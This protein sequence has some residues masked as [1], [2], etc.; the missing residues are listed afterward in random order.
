MDFFT[1][2]DLDFFSLVV[3][4]KYS[5]SSGEFKTI[6]KK[7]TNNGV[8]DKTKKWAKLL[9]ERGYTIHFR[10]DWQISGIIRSYTWAQIYYKG[11]EDTMIFF[12]VGVGSR[13]KNDSEYHLI[14]KIDYHRKKLSPY[15]VQLFEDY[16][17]QHKIESIERISKQVLKSYNWIKLADET[18]GFMDGLETYYKNLVKILWPYG[19]KV[20]PKV[21][22]LCWNDFGWQKPSGP[23]GK[24]ES[25]GLA[26]EK[27]KGYGYEE[28]LFDTDRLINGYHY[29]FIQP[30]NKGKHL[31]K[32]YNL[33]LYTIK[34]EGNISKYYWI[35]HITKAE[36]LSVEERAEI[37]KLYKNNGWYREMQNELNTVGVAGFDFGP[38]TEDDMFNVKFKASD[39]IF[40]IFEP[41]VE[42]S[43]PKKEVSGGFHYVLSDLLIKTESVN[44]TS[45]L[46]RFRSGHNKTKTGKTKASYTVRTIDKT[47]LHKTIQESMYNQ[48]CEQ[49]GIKNVGT[50]VNTGNGTSIDLVVKGEDKD[51][52]YEVKMS[53]SALKC[54]RDGLGQILEY[55]MY[56]NNQWCSKMIIVG[57][58][59]ADEKVI[60]YILHL[61]KT[62]NISLY[63]Q[64]FDL[65]SKKL[66]TPII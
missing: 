54:I 61:R 42:I 49:Y 44:K 35:G 29:G 57:P 65:N 63:Y 13:L 10:N 36:V 46:Y 2:N 28:W 20:S 55:S 27:D 40:T 47:L 31:G 37:L 24:S 16:L 4:K 18:E 48:L 17:K 59:Y 14:Y 34:R 64:T 32:V 33:H 5:K 6:G 39:E 51:V 38:I 56:V 53:G 43:E 58:Y 50:E 23:Y 45:G 52:F 1:K 7:L 30:L 8:Y 60:N 66:I 25:T 22:R 3:G 12:T 41:Y 21:A 15:Q 62:L 19:S 11:F 26:F 9:E